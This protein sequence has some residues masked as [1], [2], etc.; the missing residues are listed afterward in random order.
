MRA[1]AG[2]RRERLEQAGRKR[3][4]PHH[5]QRLDRQLV[6]HRRKLSQHASFNEE[7]KCARSRYFVILDA[8]DRLVPGCLA[9]AV[10]VMDQYSDVPFAYGSAVRMAAP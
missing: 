2:V 10:N 6:G 4:G 7:V 1:S 5:R 9:R 3:P 8:G